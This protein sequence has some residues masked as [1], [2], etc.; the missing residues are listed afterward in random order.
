M[1]RI[2]GLVGG[3]FNLGFANVSDGPWAVWPHVRNMKVGEDQV[4]EEETLLRFLGG[5]P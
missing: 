3:Q 5:L 1:G 2:T 4:E